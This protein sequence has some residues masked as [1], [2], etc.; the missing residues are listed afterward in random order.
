MKDKRFLKFYKR[1]ARYGLIPNHGLC[2]CDLDLYT[3]ALVTPSLDD[4]KELMD[5]NLSVSYWGSGL[6]NDTNIELLRYKFTELR[7]NIVLLCAAIND[8]L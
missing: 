5:N 3:L 4:V 8:E 6:A 7:Q 2:T 1:C